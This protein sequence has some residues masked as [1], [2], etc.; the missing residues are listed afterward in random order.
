MCNLYSLTKGQ[1]ANAS[2]HRAT[3]YAHMPA[4]EKR[5]TARGVGQVC[6]REVLWSGGRLLGFSSG[7]HYS[8]RADRENRIGKDEPHHRLTGGTGFGEDLLELGRDSSI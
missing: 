6:P 5:L 4:T 2:V 1:A 3:S 8:C 7:C